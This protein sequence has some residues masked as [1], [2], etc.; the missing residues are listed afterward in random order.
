M[1]DRYRLHKGLRYARKVAV[2]LVG[3]VVTVGGAA[4]MPLPGPGIAVL[5]LGLA[6]LAIEFRSA[7][8]AQRYVQQQAR[9]ALDRAR[10]RAALRR[11]RADRRRRRRVDAPAG[12]RRTGGVRNG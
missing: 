9:R 6:I 5:L 1:M 2:G 10:R 12:P 4:L 8:R 11:K 3:G 7:R